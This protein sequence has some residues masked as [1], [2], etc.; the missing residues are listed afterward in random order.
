M[1]LNWL[2]YPSGL[3]QD[4]FLLLTVLPEAFCTVHERH[5]ICGTAAYKGIYCL[6]EDPQ[7]RR[8]ELQYC[9]PLTAHRS[10]ED[11]QL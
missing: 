3:S 7:G 2:D 9:R 1:S 4:T 5:K 6:V 8:A 11:I 10:E